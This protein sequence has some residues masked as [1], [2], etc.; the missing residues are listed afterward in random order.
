MARKSNLEVGV[1]V[2][3][4]YLARNGGYGMRYDL[5]REFACRDGAEPLRLNAYVTLPVSWIERHCR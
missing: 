3:V 1:F 4:A 5:L 2:D